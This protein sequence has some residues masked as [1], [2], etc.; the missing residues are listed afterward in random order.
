MTAERKSA[1]VGRLVGEGGAEPQVRREA[2]HSWPRTHPQIELANVGRHRDCLEQ[3]SRQRHLPPYRP[4]E[5]GRMN[6]GDVDAA[7]RRPTWPLMIVANAASELI[8]G[9]SDNGKEHGK[10]F[11]VLR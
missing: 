11:S 8:G 4:L 10:N 6:G 3:R 9:L 7:K 2:V 5:N 1:R